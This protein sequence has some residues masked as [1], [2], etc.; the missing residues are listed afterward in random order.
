MN[1][2]WMVGAGLTMA[3]LAAQA[4]LTGPTTLNDTGMAH[5]VT[6]HGKLTSDCTGTGQDGE[7]GRDATTPRKA[8][9]HA[10]FKYAKLDAGGHGLPRDAASWHCVADRVTGLVWEMKTDHGVH[11]ANRLYTNYGDGS[12]GDTSALVAAANARTLC[13][14]SNWRLPTV[15]ELQGLIDY[16]AASGPQID[17]AWFPNTREN[18]YWT[19]TGYANDP[20]ASWA[21][22]FSAGSGGDGAGQRM[23]RLGARLVHDTTPAT[24]PADPGTRYAFAGDE[25]T[26]TWT[27]LVWKRCSAGQAWSGT[28]CTG[29]LKETEWADALNAAVAESTR[30]G[31]AWRL[32]NAK[33]LSSIMD[34]STNYPAMD[35]SVF[36]GTPAVAYYWTSTPSAADPTQAWTLDIRGGY[37]QTYPAAG[38]LIAMRFVRSE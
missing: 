16:G 6:P 36:P 38:Y 14:A 32:P 3:A 27:S 17:A 12:S 19:S 2:R 21:V 28:Q 10:G 24:L 8:D 31:L 9:G 7:T 11:G 22:Y 18:W 37:T 1:S 23:F 13:G 33:E 30:T 25:V 34:R 29:M 35:L 26:D 5:C 15:N 4:Q 20:L